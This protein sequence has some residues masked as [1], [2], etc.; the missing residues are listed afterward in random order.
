MSPLDEIHDCVAEAQRRHYQ[1]LDIAH[2][3]SRVGMRELADELMEVAD[4]IKVG[5]K[6]VSEAYSLH[7]SGQIRQSEAMMGSLLKATLA[8]CIV[9]PKRARAK[10]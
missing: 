5:P 10:S 1:L 8:G 9:P 3:L 4:A 7:L 6:A 2:A